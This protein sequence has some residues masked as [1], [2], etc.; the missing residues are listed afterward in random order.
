MVTWTSHFVQLIFCL[1]HIK[2][3]AVQH[4]LFGW[5]PGEYWALHW[6]PP[7]FTDACDAVTSKTY[8]QTTLTAFSAFSYISLLM[9]RALLQ[10]STPPSADQ[11]SCSSLLR[12]HN[13]K[14]PNVVTS[15]GRLELLWGETVSG[16]L[17]KHTCSY[18]ETTQTHWMALPFTDD[19]MSLLKAFLADWKYVAP[20]ALLCCLS[21]CWERGVATCSPAACLQVMQVKP[22]QLPY[23]CSSPPACRKGPAPYSTHPNTF[24]LRQWY[25]VKSPSS[26]Y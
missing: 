4:K 1:I 7:K 21:L 8:N 14:F 25:F 23:I 15:L 16:R 9:Q 13:R 24:K 20:S 12:S 6:R 19:D 17:P 10:G 5:A 3:P 2:G 26:H 11:L 22:V 18:T